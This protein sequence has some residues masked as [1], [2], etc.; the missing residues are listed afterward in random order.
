MMYDLSFHP[1]HPQ[2]IGE[3]IEPDEDGQRRNDSIYD[4][5]EFYNS[6]LNQYAALSMSTGATVIRQRNSKKKEIQ[7]KASKGRRLIYI[8]QCL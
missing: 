8:V 7:R 6:L 4:D 3:E 2:I 1:F 5:Q